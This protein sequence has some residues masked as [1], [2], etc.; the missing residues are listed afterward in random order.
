MSVT[1][2]RECEVITDLSSDTHTNRQL[3]CNRIYEAGQQLT[4]TPAL[5]IQVQRAD[6]YH[7]RAEKHNIAQDFD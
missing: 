3:N 1:D 7:Q 6:T 2:T 5:Q 4:S